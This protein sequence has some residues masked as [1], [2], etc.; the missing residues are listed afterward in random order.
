MPVTDDDAIAATI[1]LIE[2]AKVWA[3]PAAGCAYAAAKAIAQDLPADAVLAIVVC[4]GNASLKD[5]TSPPAG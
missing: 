2:E 1:E 4:G 3:E 5:I